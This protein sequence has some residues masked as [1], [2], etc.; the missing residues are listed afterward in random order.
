[1]LLYASTDKKA[2][3][4]QVFLIVIQENPNKSYLPMKVLEYPLITLEYS[5]I[6]QKIIH[7]FKLIHFGC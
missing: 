7:S 1:M 2:I 6:S 5:I 4:W 3:D